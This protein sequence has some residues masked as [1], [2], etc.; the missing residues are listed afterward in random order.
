M[1]NLEL[2]P[3]HTRILT[4]KDDIVEA[5][6]HYAKDIIGPEDIVCVAE[7]VVAITQGH[8]TRPEELKPTWQARFL[9]RFVPAEGSMSSVYGMQAAMELE[10][11]WKVMGAFFI[12][13]IAKLFRKNGVF[14]QLARQASL[15]DDV[16]GTMPPF[17]KHIVYGPKEPNQVAERIVRR[18]GC[19][20]AVVAD[21]ND[22]KRSAVLGHSRGMDPKKIARIL[23]DNPFG[24]DS[25]MTPIVVIKNFAAVQAK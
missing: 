20:G 3:I 2:V 12:G 9:C 21:V 24:N 7:S 19:Y 8:F 18:T 11:K 16:T 4:D 15:T 25:Q 1:A 17:D 13:A 14:Y 23:I 5:I 6:A 22:L 10:G